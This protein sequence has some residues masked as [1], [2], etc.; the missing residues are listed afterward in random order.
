M[1]RSSYPEAEQRHLGARAWGKVKLHENDQWTLKL[2]SDP[3]R[4]AA[5]HFIRP[6]FLPSL[7]ALHFRQ[8]YTLFLWFTSHL[9]CL[10]PSILRFF[11]LFLL[12]SLYTYFSLFDLP[13]PR[14]ASPYVHPLWSHKWPCQVTF[15]WTKSPMNIFFLGIY[16]EKV[17]FQ[18]KFDLARN[19]RWILWV[20]S[21]NTGISI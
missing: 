6:Y 16:L 11:Q 7:S 18:I 2:P 17:S 12:C 13:T 4:P 3:W 1:Q 14:L 15:P 10:S 5:E 19:A 21:L 9:S 8:S 20:S